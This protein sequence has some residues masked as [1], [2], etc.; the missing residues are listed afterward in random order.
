M[1]EEEVLIEK[2]KTNVG[3]ALY[4]LFKNRIVPYGGKN[5]VKTK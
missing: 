2:P 4:K 3:I 1:G 5:F